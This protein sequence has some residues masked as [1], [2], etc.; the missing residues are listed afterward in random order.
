MIRP[1]F[2]LPGEESI[3]LIIDKENALGPIEVLSS[4][5]E[6]Y[7]DEDTTKF[8]TELYNLLSKDKSED[9][10]ELMDEFYKEKYPIEEEVEED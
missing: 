5:L 7:D 9:A 4:R 3:D 1:K 6:K 10:K 2:K 8:A